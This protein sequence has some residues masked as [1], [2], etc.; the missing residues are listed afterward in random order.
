MATIKDAQ[1]EGFETMIEVSQELKRLIEKHYPMDEKG[2]FSW[3][4]SGYSPIF[5][6]CMNRL[7]LLL[8]SWKTVRKRNDL[9]EL[10]GTAT[11]KVDDLK[12][13]IEKDENEL[14]NLIIQELN[15]GIKRED[16]YHLERL[17]WKIENLEFMLESE[18]WF[19]RR[20][21]EQRRILRVMLSLQN[22]GESHDIARS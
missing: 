1:Q 21:E 6:R 11:K 15:N 3:L 17:L 7:E 19:L 2:H 16:E 13:R 20:F 22:I 8:E 18:R 9:E 12:K 10:F 4:D 14:D 5:Q